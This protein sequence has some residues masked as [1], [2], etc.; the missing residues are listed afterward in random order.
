MYCG[1]KV[2]CNARPWS[3]LEA[4]KKSKMSSNWDVGAMVVGGEVLGSDVPLAVGVVAPSV[5]EEGLEVTSVGGDPALPSTGILVVPEV[6]SVG[7]DPTLL[8]IGILVGPEVTSVG[9]DP[10]RKSVV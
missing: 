10:D 3:K 6:A 7:G 2:F 5:D 1:D 9:G 8:S 4:L